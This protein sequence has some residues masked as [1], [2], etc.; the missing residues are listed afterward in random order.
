M[1]IY[2]DKVNVN[3]KETLYR[4]LEYSLYEESLND[5]N[6]MNDDAIFEY[7]YFN[8]YFTDNNKN[9]FFIR[10]FNTNKLL[11]FVMIN[12]YIK[13]DYKEHNI[14]EFMIIPKYRRNKI[15]K[16]AAFKCFDLFKGNWK[17]SPSLNS[18]IAYLFWRNIID[19]YTNQN[20]KF[21]DGIFVFN[22]KEYNL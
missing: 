12:T 7:K 16:K 19:E 20:N 22:N 17:I 10:E 4:L 14:T 9:A 2:L 11:G 8:N 21:K 5:G 13:N 1:N 6:E 18:K 3:K 15:G